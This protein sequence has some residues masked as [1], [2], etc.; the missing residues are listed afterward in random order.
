MVGE[1]PQP[2]TVQDLW[3]LVYEKRVPVWT[4]LHTL[5]LHLLNYPGVVPSEEPQ[6]VG[7]LVIQ[8]TG[9]QVFNYFTEYYVEITAPKLSSSGCHKC[10]LL[11]MEGWPHS[12][13]LP[14]SPEPLL[15]V[16]ER[17]EAISKVKNSSLFTCKDGVT[18]CGVMMALLQLVARMKLVQEVDVYRSVLSI[19]YDRPQFITSVEQYDFLHTAAICYL[20]AFNV[21][22]NFT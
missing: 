21:Y 20:N 22:K 9:S 11:V 5:P 17:V 3:R 10:V 4:L 13:L 8:L 2:H 16:L 18:G 1:H 19:V 15:A 6:T 14:A 12:D 7:Y